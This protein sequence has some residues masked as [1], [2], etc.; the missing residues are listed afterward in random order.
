MSW[1]KIHRKIKDNWIWTD[2]IRLKWW[3]DILLTVNHEDS[4]CLIKGTLI[5]CKRGQSVRSLDTWA[6]TWGVSKKTV[7]AFFLLLKKDT[8][9][10]TENLKV[11]TRITVLNY[12]SY[13]QQKTKISD[14]KETQTG[15][16]RKRELPTNK[17]NKEYN[18][19]TNVLVLLDTNDNFLK[20]LAWQKENTPTLLAMK[21]PFTEAQ[22]EKLKKK[23]HYSRIIE[24]CQRMHN[25]NPLLKKYKSAYLTFINWV[26]LDE[27][28]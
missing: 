4:K 21:E 7:F 10:E 9:L 6:T 13:N 2:P 8:M 1:I 20:F 12:D 24:I 18:T 5:D 17:N 16:P 14:D 28:A 23:Y 27:K 22:F 26:K 11:T 19:N 15:T 25:Y 3:L